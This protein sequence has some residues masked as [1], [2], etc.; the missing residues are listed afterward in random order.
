MIVGM[1]AAVEAD[2]DLLLEIFESARPD[3]ALLPL[4]PHAKSQLVAQQRRAQLLHYATAFPGAQYFVIEADGVAAGQL[5]LWQDETQLR[6][7]DVALLRAHRGR[8]LGTVLMTQLQRQAMKARLPL[9]LAVWGWNDDALRFYRRLGFK[10]T[11]EDAGYLQLR[12]EDGV[13][14]HENDHRLVEVS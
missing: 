5:I 4:A 14:H 6:V 13:A 12:W 8:G 1:R 3:F 7:V 11:D 9:Q 10:Q 2:N